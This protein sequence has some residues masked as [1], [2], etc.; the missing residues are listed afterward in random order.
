M[1]MTARPE[2]VWGQGQG[3][4]QSQGPW[5]VRVTVRVEAVCTEGLCCGVRLGHAGLVGPEEQAVHV[6][7]LHRVIVCTIRLLL[8]EKIIL[9]RVTGSNAC[10]GE[11]V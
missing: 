6:G 2:R 10:R 7:Q 11:K 3:E 5:S 8:L 9:S 1:A 4:G